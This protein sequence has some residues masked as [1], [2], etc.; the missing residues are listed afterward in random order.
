MID[1]NIENIPQEKLDQFWS[2]VEEID[3][4]NNCGGREYEQI[5][6]RLMREKDP[7]WVKEASAIRY[8]LVS[9]LSKRL[10]YWEQ[11]PGNRIDLG[12]DSFSDLLNH[13]V[14]LGKEEFEKSLEDL[15][16]IKRRANEY[17]FKESFSYCFPHEGDYKNLKLDHYQELAKE[18]SKEFQEIMVLQISKFIQDEI[19]YIVETLKMIENG[20]VKAALEREEETKDAQ[21]KI[22]KF[23]TANRI[24]IGY[25]HGVE[26]LFHD[27]K[28]YQPAN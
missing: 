28:L 2:L 6:V 4:G 11:E 1:L 14:G 15:S 24:S 5:S 17:D 10:S 21:E 8:A 25:H 27:I 18:Y 13:I 12:D 20:D 16:R 23:C 26:N 19:L 9:E 3:W 22:V 7:N